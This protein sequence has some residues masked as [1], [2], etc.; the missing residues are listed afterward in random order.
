MSKV[1][2]IKKVIADFLRAGDTNDTQLL[3]NVLHPHYQNIQ[4]GLFEEQGIHVITRVEYIEFVGS[5][6]FGGS[7]RKVDFL[8]VEEL[9][10]IAVAKVKLES[11]YLIF[12]SFITAV[13][14]DGCWKIINNTPE[15]QRKMPN[16]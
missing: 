2:E 7:P 13:F 15:A 6:R 9:E 1:T 11:E 16:N 12:N 8:F 5:K 4:N 3:S 10:N 14:V